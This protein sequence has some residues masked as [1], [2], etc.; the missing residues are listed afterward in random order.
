[1][2]KQR[3]K[4][5]KRKQPFFSF[6][7]GILRLFKKGPK[8][9]IN[10]AG[11][12]NPRAIIIANHSAKAGPLLME[13]YFPLYH[14]VWGAGEMLGNYKS[15]F[16]Y[17]RDVFYMQKRGFSKFTATIIAT[18][19]AIFSPLIYKGMRVL[20]TFTNGKLLATVNKS[21]EVLKNDV[22]VLIFPENSNDGYFEEMTQF[23]P[24]FVLLAQ[25]Y[26]HKTGEDVPIYP[27]YYHP[28]KRILCIDKPCYVQ[29]YVNKGLSRAQIAEIFKQKVNDLYHNYCSD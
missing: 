29:D 22:S 6:I 23:F 1:M 28:K 9:I 25:L 24:G 4:Q 20:P 18:F 14:Y 7:K 21:I 27:V 16:H 10:L 13:L 26:Y 3:K 5:I 19:E 17:L 11:E 8:K 12:L 15:R 2:K